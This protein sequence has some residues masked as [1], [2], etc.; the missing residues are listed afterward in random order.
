MQ[1]KLDEAREA[2]LEEYKKCA[3]EAHRQ[4]LIEKTKNSILN[5]FRKKENRVDVKIEDFF[6]EELRTL[7]RAYKDA[8]VSLGNSMYYAKKAELE[9][10]KSDEELKDELSKY[11]STEILQK[12]VIEERQ[13][14]IDANKEKISLLKKM[15][16]GYRKMPRWKR[17]ALSTALFTAAAGAGVVSA[18]AFAGSGLLGLAGM[19]TFKFAKSMAIGVAVG[20]ATKS[21]DWLSKKNDKNFETRQNIQKTNLQEQYGKGDISL[22]EYEKVS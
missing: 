18:G 5:I 8:K 12:V 1:K 6:T 10:T 2:Y 20:H 17:V 21:I 4:N 16:D 13:K 9:K 14:V 22:E 3:K 19:A 7:E 11:K 15:L